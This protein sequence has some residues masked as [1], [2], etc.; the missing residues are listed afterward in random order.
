[1]SNIVLIGFM[2]CGKTTIGTALA[3]KTGYRLIDTDEEIVKREGRTINE[4]FSGESEKY[5]R[6]LETSMIKE[7]AGELDDC[8]I[9]TGGGLPVTEG[10]G[11]LLRKLG[12]VVY[13]KATKETVLKRVAGDTSRPLLAGDAKEKTAKLLQ[14]RTPIYERT[15]QI[16]IVTDNRAVDDITAEV[17]EKVK[18]FEISD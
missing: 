10:N 12:I 4:I 14:Y 8:I 13:L 17:M 2:G 15:A 5:F 16:Q 7:M 18:S 1:M 11:E 9:S 6:Q 3:K